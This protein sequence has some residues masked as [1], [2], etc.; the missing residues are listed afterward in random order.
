FAPLIPGKHLIMAKGDDLTACCEYY[1]EH[2]NE[3]EAI[4]GAAYDFV[5]ERVTQESNCR[6]FLEQIE[7][8]FPAGNATEDFS[9]NAGANADAPVKAEPLP[10]MLTKRISRKPMDL[11]LSAL[12]DDFSNILRGTKR[13][14][15]ASARKPKVLTDTARN[16]EVISNLRRG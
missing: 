2:G 8:S 3:R 1:L 14:R 6:A 15:P 5:R 4:A 7:N 13:E 10:E 12:R 9:L 11:L 16:I